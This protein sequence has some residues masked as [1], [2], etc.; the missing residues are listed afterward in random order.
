MFKKLIKKSTLLALSAA[1]ISAFA[2]T[3]HDHQSTMSFV[4]HAIWLA[5]V[6]IAA[7]LIVNVLRKRNEAKKLAAKEIKNVT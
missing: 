2:H 5:P 6:A 3:G 4:I 1:P 7:Y